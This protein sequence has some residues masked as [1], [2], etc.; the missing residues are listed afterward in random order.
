MRLLAW[1]SLLRTTG[2]GHWRM[3]R[4][5]DLELIREYNQETDECP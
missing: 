3:G 5:S 1:L 4:S 2:L